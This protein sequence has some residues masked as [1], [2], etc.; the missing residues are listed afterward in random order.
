[1]GILDWKHEP[2]HREKITS[3]LKRRGLRPDFSE[4]WE[5]HGPHADMN[6]QMFVGYAINTDDPKDTYCVTVWPGHGVWEIDDPSQWN[7]TD[8]TRRIAVQ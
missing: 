3:L 5:V 2:Y 7:Q 1:M 6:F 4:L 8:P